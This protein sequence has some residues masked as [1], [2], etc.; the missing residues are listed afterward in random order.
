MIETYVMRQYSVSRSVRAM[1]D[2]TMLSL[3]HSVEKMKVSN[4][5]LT[6]QLYKNGCFFNKTLN[7]Q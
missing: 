1:V 6:A 4:G 2:L 5:I 3:C 7:N